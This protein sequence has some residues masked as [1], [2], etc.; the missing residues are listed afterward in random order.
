MHVIKRGAEAVLY[1]EERDGKKV[2]VK[3]RVKKG[4]RIPE[5]DDSIRSSRTKREDKL[6]L[7]AQRSGVNVP[8][9]LAAE[10]T[11]LVM[12]YL[13]GTTVKE[14]LNG[15]ARGDRLEVYEQIGRAAA[16]LHPQ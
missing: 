13:D 10:K 3:D 9:V 5:L 15:M 2:L 14:S 16:G 6:M 4:Y 7:R 8:Q 1:V 12:E 11:K